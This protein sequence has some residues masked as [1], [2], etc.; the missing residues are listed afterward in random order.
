MGYRSLEANV[1]GGSNIAVGLSA[2][3]MNITGG[4]NT[5]VGTYALQH[6]LESNNT[7]ISLSALEQNT[8][9]SNNIAV[10]NVS[11]QLNRTGGL[12]VALGQASLNMN[13]GSSNTAIG[14]RTLAY[15]T[16]GQNNVAIGSGTLEGN[17]RGSGLT[18]IGAGSNVIDSSLNNSTIIGF[19]GRVSTSNTMSFG[20]AAVNKWAF[21][22]PT[23]PYALQVG[24]NTGNGNGAYL[25]TGGTW[26][27]AS[28]IHFKENFSEIS[29]DEILAKINSLEIPRWSY[30]GTTETHIGPLAEQFKEVFGLGVADDNEHISTIDV[31]GVALRAVQAL[32]YK[33]RVYE[34]KIM[35][36][37]KSFIE[38]EKRIQK[39]EKIQRQQK[40]IMLI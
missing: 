36:L 23:T 2:L 11:L 8:T 39:L 17:S 33:N 5:A 31:S 35:Q 29:N 9:G 34:E 19:D 7:G 28:S 27:N 10:G 15:N 26:T 20:N 4:G 3:E 24:S 21:G 32:M 6:N 1:S 14:N 12:N 16:I 13:N 38:L 18:A 40:I 22:L 25:T 30:K 37:E